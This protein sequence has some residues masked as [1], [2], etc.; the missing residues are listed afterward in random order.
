MRWSDCWVKIEASIGA[1]RTKCLD[2]SYSHYVWNVKD[3]TVMIAPEKTSV[4]ISNTQDKYNQHP[5]LV[6]QI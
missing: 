1:G 3:V 2:S 6:T 5:Y 4:K